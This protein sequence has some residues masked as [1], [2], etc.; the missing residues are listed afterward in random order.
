M[1]ADLQYPIGSLS[2]PIK[3]LLANADANKAEK[4]RNLL[5]ILE[6][7][8]I[9][10][11][12]KNIALGDISGSIGQHVNASYS[13]IGDEYCISGSESNRTT[14]EDALGRGIS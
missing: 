12:K 14:A 5:S 6:H 13:C 7:F 10:E 4:L 11:T 8:F 3:S 2:G 9:L 1:N